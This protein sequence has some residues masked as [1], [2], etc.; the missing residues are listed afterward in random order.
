MTAGCPR[1]ARPVIALCKVRN[2]KSHLI[3]WSRLTSRI[4]THSV[5]VGVQFVRV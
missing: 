3:N 5:T 4:A 1:V 2:A